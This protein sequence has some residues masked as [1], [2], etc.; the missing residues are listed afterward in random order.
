M[1]VIVISIIILIVASVIV[2]QSFRNRCAII[3]KEQLE[4]QLEI[5]KEYFKNLE[6]NQAEIKEMKETID[7]YFLK[8]ESFLK[9]ETNSDENSKFSGN[10]NE[11]RADYENISELECSGISILNAVMYD[12]KIKAKEKNIEFTYDLNCPAIKIIDDIDIVGL[13]G[14]IIDNA[15]EAANK[16]VSDKKVFVEAQY[17]KGVLHIKC[18]NSKSTEDNPVENNFETTKNNKFIHGWGRKIIKDIVKKYGGTLKEIDNKDLFE[19]DILLFGKEVE[20]VKH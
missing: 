3:K 18:I 20:N 2:F 5:E 6:K 10:F 12:K 14:N 19:L 1:L 7:K 15:I 9:E 4:I 11:L 13:F 16:A 8:I 17:Y